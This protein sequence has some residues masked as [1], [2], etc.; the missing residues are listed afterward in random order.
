MTIYLVGLETHEQRYTGEWAEYLPEQIRHALPNERV[1][2]IKGLANRQETTP[3]AF[4]NFAATN[5]FKSQQITEIAGLFER[6]L[7]EAGDCF[8]FTDAWHYGV[9][10]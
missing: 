10:A 9:T 7:V 3:G 5:I 4:L 1:C 8:L 6:Q 2:I